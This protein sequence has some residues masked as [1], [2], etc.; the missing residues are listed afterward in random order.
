MQ[1]TKTTYRKAPQKHLPLVG[2]I[3]LVG[4]AFADAMMDSTFVAMMAA[5][6]LYSV[7]FDAIA[8]AMIA[9]KYRRQ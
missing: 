9:S 5:S 1:K 8:V 4:F 2:V 6:Q 3:D 7:A